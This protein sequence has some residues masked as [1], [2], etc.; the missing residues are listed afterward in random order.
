M[1]VSGQFLRNR[2]PL[3]GS[4][5]AAESTAE[6]L[7]AARCAGTISRLDDVNVQRNGELAACGPVLVGGGTVPRRAAAC[8][9]LPKEDT[10]GVTEHDD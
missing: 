6:L 9:Y 7:S 4:Y 1:L 5:Q 10:C 8:D 3:A 2:T